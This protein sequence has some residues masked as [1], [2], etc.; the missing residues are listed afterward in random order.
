[1][2]PDLISTMERV[3]VSSSTLA[4]VG[5]DPDGRVLEVRFRHG[6]VY[7]YLDVPADVYRELMAAASH[8]SYLARVV[9]P[10]Y[11]FRRVE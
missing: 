4:S 10:N 6:G 5:Y 9:K 8:G 3:P 2:G 1:M 7:Q 11:A